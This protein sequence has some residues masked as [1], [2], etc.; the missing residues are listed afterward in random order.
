MKNWIF[1]HLFLVGILI[2]SCQPPQGCQVLPVLGNRD[3]QGTDTVY[4][5][6]PDFTFM[7]QDSQSVT[8]ATFADKIY[9]VDFFFISCPTICP[10]VKKQMLRVYQ[11]FSQ[12]PRLLLLS[13][14]IDVRHDTIPRLKAYADGLGI[15]TNR[16]HLVTGSEDDIYQIAGNYFSIAKK[17]PSV[18]GGFDHSGRLILVDEDRRVRSFCDG[19]DPQSVDQFMT[20]IQCLLDER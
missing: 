1:F 16:W 3:I 12:E 13:H 9:V 11:R 4:A 19:T 18:P 15:S 2:I 14:T 17:D 5:T 6:I 10:K 7:D 20:D 8:N